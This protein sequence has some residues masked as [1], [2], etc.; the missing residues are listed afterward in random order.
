[1]LAD[2]CDHR[3][4]ARP[5]VREYGSKAAAMKAAAKKTVP[6]KAARNGSLAIQWQPRGTPRLTT[7]S[8]STD[9]QCF[10]HWVPSHPA[11][12]INRGKYRYLDDSCSV[13]SNLLDLGEHLVETIAVPARDET[14]G[15]A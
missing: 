12:G 9:E 10:H 3:G 4:R 13:K 7:T 15:E 6:K 11:T 8:L 5:S 1:M 2:S 14:I